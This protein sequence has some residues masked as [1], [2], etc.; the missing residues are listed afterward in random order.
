MS[1]IDN[2]VQGDRSPDDVVD[3]AAR[4]GEKA[5]HASRE[6]DRRERVR[7]TLSSAASARCDNVVGTRVA[8]AE[9]RPDDRWICRGIR[10]D[11][12]WPGRADLARNLIGKRIN[13]HDDGGSPPPAGRRHPSAVFITLLDEAAVAITGPDPSRAPVVAVLAAAART[14]P[15]ARP[16]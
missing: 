3:G 14:A 8:A 1:G 15:V 4:T 9:G 5:L 6:G 13:Q 10:A 7:A 16:S 2:L 12:P 11:L